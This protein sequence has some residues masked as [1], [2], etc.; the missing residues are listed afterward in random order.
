M[1]AENPQALLDLLQGTDIFAG[2]PR[3]ILES[4]L[5][6]FHE[7][8]FGQGAN[9]IRKG[10][11]GSELFIILEG[12]VKVHDGDV[13]VARLAEGEYFGEMSL[14]QSAPRSMS[15]SVTRPVRALVIDQDS[16]YRLLG[17]HP[18]LIQRL[19]GGIL[20]RLRHQTTAM[21]DELRSRETELQLE[22]ERQTALYR[23]QKERAERSERFKQQFL[24][25]MS[26]EIRTPM[27]AVMGM[28]NLVLDSTLQPRQRFYL[29]R[30]RKS[31][32]ILLHLLND[33][34]DL[35]K[36]EAGKM[37]L[38]RIDFSLRDVMEQ[39][40]M[41][42]Q[43]KADE[44]NLELLLL[45]IHGLPDACVGDP[46][47]LHQVLLN[48]AGNAI[49]FT[50]SGSVCLEVTQGSREHTLHFSVSDTGIGIPPERLP[51]IFDDFTQAHVSD[52]RVY[53]GTGLGLSI[54]RQLV[55]LMGGELTVDSQVGAGS[56][57]SF[58]IPLE[59]GSP[60]RLRLR[61]A[62]QGEIDGDILEGV[63][64]L[65]VDDNEYNR[66]VVNDTLESKT[67]A[68]VVSCDSGRAALDRLRSEKFDVVL[69]DVRMPEMNGFEATRIIRSD[70]PEP[71]RHI[72]VIA[73]TAS[74]LRTDLELCLAAG[75]NGYVPKP[76]TSDQLIAAIAGILHIPL[77]YREAY[78]PGVLDPA[79]LPDIRVRLDALRSFCEGDERQ[80]R[81]YLDLFL[82]SAPS[83]IDQLVHAIEEGD[84]TMI[85][86]LIHA[87]K[88]RWLMLG[89]RETHAL[90]ASI[91]ANCREGAD[92]AA[93]REE[94]DT[95]LGHIRAAI[96]AAEG[97][98]SG[99][100]G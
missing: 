27:N 43:H 89:L 11:P 94:L 40:R 14:L 77:R 68:T 78:F 7:H 2:I 24:A 81:K 26:H 59:P 82:E 46:V 70:F 60:A 37:E 41:T 33:I 13:T 8:T 25:N 9:I 85:A 84:C 87:F 76:F 3:E 32:D 99:L 30:I 39:V 57:F 10:D 73:L 67:R 62:G 20:N 96:P 45:G 38:E 90:A 17:R 23:E 74:V 44:K 12:E 98:R 22:V 88:T 100:A 86:G 75:M 1:L 55:A 50:D 66:I 16:F 47:R 93:V 83:L 49:K 54:C 28:T 61:Q 71:A 34:L 53:G 64:I 29:E 91:E 42:L 80:M 72:P 56:T 79:G 5:S 15:I 6:Y 31:S 21:V 92:I 18:E 52:N 19:V 36:I 65:V 51:L 35:S 95:L 4:H 63:R 97:V 48:L 69:M 58:T